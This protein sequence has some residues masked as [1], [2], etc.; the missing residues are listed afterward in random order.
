MRAKRP[1]PSKAKQEQAKSSK[2]EY[3]AQC[4]NSTLSVKDKLKYVHHSKK[5][6]V[7]SMFRAKRKN[8]IYVCV[9]HP[10]ASSNVYVLF[11]PRSTKKMSAADMF[12]SKQIMYYVKKNL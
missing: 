5:R 3:V 8:N 7:K 2:H 12:K 11:C 9:S 4:A 1:P 6:Y 10:I